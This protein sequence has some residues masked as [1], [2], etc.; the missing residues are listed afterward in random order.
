M[1]HGIG[2]LILATVIC[3]CSR[4]DEPFLKAP[5]PTGQFM[6]QI[7]RVSVQSGDHTEDAFDIAL[8]RSQDKYFLAGKRIPVRDTESGVYLVTWDTEA[9]RVAVSLKEEGPPAFEESYK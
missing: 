6:I 7:S 9:G 3:S 5:D 1:K 2:I 4:P 8:V